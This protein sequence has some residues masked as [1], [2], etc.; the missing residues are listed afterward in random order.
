[1]LHVVPGPT[2]EAA[3]GL[4]CQVNLPPHPLGQGPHPWRSASHRGRLRRGTA[5]RTTLLWNDW[6][7]GRLNRHLVE[8][9]VHSAPYGKPFASGGPIAVSVLERLSLAR[10]SV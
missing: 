5:H 2:G 9:D 6:P 10:C 4:P 8:S 7:V 3:T 1:M